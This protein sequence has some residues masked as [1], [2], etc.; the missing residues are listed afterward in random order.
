MVFGKV[1]KGMDVVKNIERYGSQSGKTSAPV[2][3]A[4]CGQLSWCAPRAALLQRWLAR[5]RVLRVLC[6][7]PPPGQR[8]RADATWLGCCGLRRMT[9]S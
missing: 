6:W 9:A 4:D 3:I 1:V 5:R 7:Q 8:A 2:V